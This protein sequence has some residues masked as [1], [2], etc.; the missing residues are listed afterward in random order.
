MRQ[1]G[2]LFL[3]FFFFFL[4]FPKNPHLTK[5]NF[6]KNRQTVGTGTDRGQVKKK[7]KKK[8]H[9]S[10]ANIHIHM[11]SFLFEQQI[12]RR[13]KRQVERQIYRK[14]T[15]GSLF[16]P[17]TSLAGPPAPSP[18]VPACG[19]TPSPRTVSTAASTSPPAYPSGIGT[20]T[21]SPQSGGIL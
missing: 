4:A 20:D 21:S 8:G 11:Q 2:K 9:I 6:F 5:K 14:I 7:T 15:I 16:F 18:P 13:I 17:N 3:Y 19:A 12:E 1:K 10:Y